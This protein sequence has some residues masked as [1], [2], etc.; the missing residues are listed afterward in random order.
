MVATNNHTIFVVQD[1]VDNYAAQNA[2]IQKEDEILKINNKR[3]FTENDL[4]NIMSKS[5][6]EELIL[7]IKRNDEIKEVSLYPTKQEY[8]NTGIYL[9]SIDTGDTT[10]II[11]VEAKSVAE[12]AGIKANDKILKINGKEVKNQQE[13]VQRNNEELEIILT[14]E[15]M[16]DY[17][18]GIYFKKEQT[19]IQNNLYYSFFETRDFAFS[20]IDNLKMLVTGNVRIDQFMGPV[21][22]SEVVA[23]TNNTEEFVYILALISLSL[24]VTNL[25][26][27]P[28]LDG[29]KFLLLVIEGVRRKKISEKVEINI[30]LI[31]FAILIT[32]SLYITYHDILRIL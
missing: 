8:K 21:G 23:N 20:I 25:L 26:P 17:Y 10:E 15:T 22:I 4:N 27:I 12:K 3:L 9:K 24:G 13:I 31:G 30:S 1:V 14:P 19:N 32:L 6:G 29:G 11:T 28:S 16:E 5:N 18:L 2:Q 7:T